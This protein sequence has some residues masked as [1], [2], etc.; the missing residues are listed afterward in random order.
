VRFLSN[1]ARWLRHPGNLELDYLVRGMS[2]KARYL[3]K[4]LMSR[5]GPLGVPQPQ[6][7]LADVIDAATYPDRWREQMSA[8]LAA[9]RGFAPEPYA[10]PLTLFHAEIRPFLCSFD[11]HL[12]WSDVASGGLELHAVSGNHVSMLHEPQVQSLARQLSDCL[13]RFD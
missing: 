11:P 5:L 8:A 13:R 4:V 10:G 3:W 6:F 7:E 2:R 1:L 9:R 12:G